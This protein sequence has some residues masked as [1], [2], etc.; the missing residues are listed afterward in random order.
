MVATES[1]GRTAEVCVSYGPLEGKHVGA[2]RR[3]VL[4]RQYLFHCSC[5]ACTEDLRRQREERRWRRGNDWCKHSS[6]D[7]SGAPAEFRNSPGASSA[8]AADADAD[9][10][11]L[12][13]EAR[14]LCLELEVLGAEMRRLALLLTDALHADRVCSSQAQRVTAMQRL[15]LLPQ[16]SS[17]TVAA[18]SATKAAAFS[19]T[20]AALC[21][22]G[23][24]MEAFE[25]LRLDPVGRRLQILQDR[26]FPSA[27]HTNSRQHPNSRTQRQGQGQMQ[28]PPA[29]LFVLR[30]E[31]LAAQALTV[32]QVAVSAHAHDYLYV[33]LCGLRCAQWDMKA[34]LLAQRNQYAEAAQLVDSALQLLAASGLYRAWDVALGRETVKLAQL[35]LSAGDLAASLRAATWAREVLEPVLAADDP[36]VQEVA[37]LLHFLRP[38]VHR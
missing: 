29:R 21:Q 18:T 34:R 30:P 35:L 13:S 15:G 26:Y 14:Q 12:V 1:I 10:D 25:A 7:S 3:D 17:K 31:S 24:V 11:R 16:P 9:C 5:T 37:H 2:L 20:A 23:S 36:D 33:D 19:A 22:R 28:M 8:A 6:N 38:R 4:L 27:L 32:E